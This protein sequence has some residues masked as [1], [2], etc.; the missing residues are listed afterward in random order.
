[1]PKGNYLSETEKAQIAFLQRQGLSNRKIALEIGRSR[2]V[3][4]NFVLKGENYGVKPPTSGNTKTTKRQ[5]NQLIALASKGK[6]TTMEMI[7]ELDL[8]IKKSRACKILN[9]SGH[10]KYTKRQRIP[11]LKPHHITARMAW[12]QKYVLVNGMDKSGVFRREKVKSRRS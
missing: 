4:C 9:S 10:F 3:V 11:S 6:N 5:R 1:M 2:T 8:P 12:A 7:A